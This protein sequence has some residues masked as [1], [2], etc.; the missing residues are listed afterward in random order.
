[1]CEDNYIDPIDP[2]TINANF[3]ATGDPSPVSGVSNASDSGFADAPQP[4]DTKDHGAPN[5]ATVALSV[6]ADVK[7]DKKWAELRDSVVDELVPWI[8]R[9]FEAYIKQGQIL[10]ERVYGG[11]EARV[12]DKGNHRSNDKATGL[13]QAGD[14][15]SLA[16]VAA[17]LA[18]RGLPVAVNTLRNHI[19]AYLA[20]RSMAPMQA[21]QVGVVGLVHLQRAPSDKREAVKAKVLAA[22]KDGAKVAKV[23]SARTKT[24]ELSAD[25]RKKALR[26]AKK[27]AWCD[28]L[29]RLMQ[30]A[31]L[32]PDRDDLL[33]YATKSLAG[34]A[35]VTKAVP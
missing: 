10:F 9:A 14:R 4:K 18:S 12:H 2:E 17:G 21:E 28:A 16:V 30:D 5:S 6:L 27:K 7:D 35:E 32:S 8:G 24:A 1:M 19:Q 20:S 13:D 15:D 33:A 11:D 26:A 29:D 22:G 25:D 34:I 31:V 3:G 23:E